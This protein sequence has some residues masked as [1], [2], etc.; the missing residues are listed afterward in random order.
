MIKH[1]LTVIA[2]IL[3]SVISINAVAQPERKQLFNFDWRFR[4]D[5][6]K[7]WRSLD[8]PHDWSVE[9]QVDKD[10]PMGTAGGYFPS[11]IGIYEK[12]FTLGEEYAKYVVSFLNQE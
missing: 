12:N 11:G 8:L 5:G 6:A 7:E 1:Y 2:L 4:L 3:F 10:A 9:G